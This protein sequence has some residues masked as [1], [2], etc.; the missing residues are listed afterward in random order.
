M[1]S[2]DNLGLHIGQVYGDQTV[3]ANASDFTPRYCVGSRLPHTWI[4]FAPDSAIAPPVSVDL[5]YIPD[6]ELPAERKT[7]MTHST[8]DLVSSA[9][10]TLLVDDRIDAHACLVERLRARQ[11]PVQVARLGVDYTV[12]GEAGAAWVQACGLGNGGALAIRPDQHIMARIEHGQSAATA[13][14]DVLAALGL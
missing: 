13:S 9:A 4:R 10:V 5:S 6:A 2:F 11:V 1:P 7:S 12:V 8:L 3:P 14:A